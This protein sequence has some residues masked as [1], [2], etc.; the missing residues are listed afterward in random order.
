MQLDAMLSLLWRDRK[1]DPYIYCQKSCIANGNIK[2][3]TPLSIQSIF[4]YQAKKPL[5]HYKY[6]DRLFHNDH[7][8][9]ELLLV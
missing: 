7:D 4:I 1:R 9:D 8:G 5:T 2:Y 3:E 6:R